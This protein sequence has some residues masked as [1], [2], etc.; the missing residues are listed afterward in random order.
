MVKDEDSYTLV[1]VVSWGW[2]RCTNKRNPGVF[3]RVTKF[4]D[5]IKRKTRGSDLC[6]SPTFG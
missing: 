3:A 5:W 4:V 2:D 6:K 1:G